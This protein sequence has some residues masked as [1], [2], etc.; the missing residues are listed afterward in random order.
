VTNAVN[1]LA[2]LCLMRH[3]IVSYWTVNPT[4]ETTDR[5]IIIER[6]YGIWRL[7]V[8]WKFLDV[9][10]D[11]TAFIFRVEAADRQS[12][13]ETLVRYLL[14]FLFSSCRSLA[15]LTL[16]HWRWRQYI[17]PKRRKLL[18]DYMA[19]NPTRSCFLTGNHKNTKFHLF[20]LQ[21]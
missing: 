15:W 5:D 6:N 16:R 11:R 12:C 4:M 9:S 14:C 21:L 8:R 18:P 1:T 13:I 10:E 17:P 3:L 7:E 20:V 19:W 2:Y